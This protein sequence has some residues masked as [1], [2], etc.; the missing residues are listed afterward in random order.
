MY[1]WIHVGASTVTVF[2]EFAFSQTFDKA[3]NY[4]L[5][6]Y[7]NLEIGKNLY[8]FRESNKIWIN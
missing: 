1:L 7:I 8:T 5:M 2:L 6:K 4:I 3:E